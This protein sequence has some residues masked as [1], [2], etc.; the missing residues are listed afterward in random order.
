MTDNN[1][2]SLQIAEKQEFGDAI[3]QKIAQTIVKLGFSEPLTLKLP[4]FNEAEFSL[5][6]DP[7]TQ[8]R[9]LVGYWYSEHKMR[10]GQ[11]RFNGEGSFYAEFD[12]VQNHPK[13]QNC[14]VEAI[15]AWGKPD[16]IKAEAK[17]L[18]IP[19]EQPA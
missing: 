16:N 1:E 15:N 12:V 17:L 6:T 2:I 19:Q 3:C 7:F 14:F 13:K 4:V 9:D 8:S 10:I 5:V 11:I 18:D